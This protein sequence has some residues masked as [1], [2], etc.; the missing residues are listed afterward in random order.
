MAI[1]PIP[2]EIKLMFSGKLTRSSRKAI[3]KLLNGCSMEY[4]REKSALERG[5]SLYTVHTCIA[6][7]DAVIDRLCECVYGN[8]M[9]RLSTLY[10]LSGNAQSAAANAAS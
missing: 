2:T 5:Q 6:I 3:D 8:W 1:Q 7:A 10:Y 4:L 9:F